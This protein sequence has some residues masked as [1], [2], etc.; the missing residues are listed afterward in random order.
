MKFVEALD[1]L[2]EGKYVQRKEWRNIGEYI[3]LMPG[4]SHIWKIITQPQ[5]NAGNW[6]HTLADL[7]AEDWEAFS[8]SR[9]IP[10]AVVS[11]A[12]AAVQAHA[13]AQAPAAAA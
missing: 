11:T 2:L 1:A 12:E 8:H 10:A 13:Q 6:L 9:E 5:P 7:L 3:V 4:M